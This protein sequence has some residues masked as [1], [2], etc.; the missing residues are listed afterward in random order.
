MSP[1]AIG[2]LPAATLVDEHVV[3]AGQLIVVIDCTVSPI[4]T[5]LRPPALSPF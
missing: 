3:S 2:R 5:N 1:L 4:N